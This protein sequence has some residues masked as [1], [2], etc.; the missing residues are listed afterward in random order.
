MTARV[1]I[2]RPV[3]YDEIADVVVEVEVPVIGA[4]RELVQEP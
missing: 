1:V 4:L 2:P 3:I